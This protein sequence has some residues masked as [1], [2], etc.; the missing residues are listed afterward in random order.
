[1]NDVLSVLARPHCRSVLHYFR[2]H[3]I[4]G[5][6]VAD[7]A[8]FSTDHDYAD[9]DEQTVEIRLHHAVLPKLAD[10][11]LI[12][13]DAQSKTVRYHGHPQLESWLDQ[14]AECDGGALSR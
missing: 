8:E 13:Y 9:G 5:A 7:L 1:M 12:D 10:V 4:E 11:G 6:T 14:V 2:H 3:S